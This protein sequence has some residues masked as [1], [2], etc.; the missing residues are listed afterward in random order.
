MC[1]STDATA[2]ERDF[3]TEVLQKLL[4]RIEDEN[5]NGHEP[6]LVSHAWTE[7]PV[8]YIV[9]TAP[10]SDR[11][12][13]L[14]RD[15]RESI[16]DPTPWPDL[17]EAVTYYY[18]LDLQEN[19][20]NAFFRRPREPDTIRWRGDQHPGLPERPSDIPESYRYT[21]QIAP[22]QVEHRKHIRPVVAEPRRYGNPV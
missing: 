4:Q 19:Q 8:I 9:Y 14:V 20:P 17:N 5:R 15:T 21:P 13:G 22:P 1:P 16:I 11:T 10:P 6:F 18:L 3:A 12:W 7:G 2:A